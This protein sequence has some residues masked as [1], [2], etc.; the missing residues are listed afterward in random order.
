[1]FNIITFTINFHVVPY[2][3]TSNGNNAITFKMEVQGRLEIAFI[4]DRY[5]SM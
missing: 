5:F 2:Y 4:M 3:L 1:M